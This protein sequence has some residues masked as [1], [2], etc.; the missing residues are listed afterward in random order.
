MRLTSLAVAASVLLAGCSRPAGHNEGGDQSPPAFVD[1]GETC[2]IDFEHVH[3]GSGRHYFLE[4]ANAGVALFDYDEDGDLD[5]Y[6][7][8]CQL[9]DGPPDPS[10]VNRLYRNEGDNRFTP[11]DGTGL[12]DAGYG[13]GVAVGDYDGDG[14]EDVYVTNYGPNR[15]FRNLGGGRFADVTAEAGVGDQG[16]GSS[17]AFLDYDS[18]GDLDLY[19]GNYL[20]YTP[21]GDPLCDRAGTPTYCPP[22]FY[23]PQD[24]VF[25]RNNG[26]GTFSDVSEASGILSVAPGRTLGCLAAD[27]DGDGDTD[28]Y[29]TND[30]TVNRLFENLGGEFRDVGA[31]AGISYGSLGREAG[32]MGVDAGDVDGDGDLDLTVGNFSDES[33]EVQISQGG[34]RFR[35]TASTGAIARDTMPMVTFA[36]L[37]LDFDL[38]SDL[39][40]FYANGH[41]YD[42]VEQRPQRGSWAQPDQLF[43]NDGTGLFTSVPPAVAGPYFA[44]RLLG[45]GGA[46]GDLDGDGDEDIVVN[47]LLGRP[48]VLINQAR[49]NFLKVRLRPTASNPSAI[50]ARLWA[51]VSGRELLRHVADG[52]SFCSVCSRDIVFG[53]GEA[54]Q[55][56]ELLVVWPSGRES[57]LQDLPA[58]RT[59]E[60]VEP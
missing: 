33:G 52:R 53:L 5:V 59:V 12:E 39:D 43:A 2:G 20:D 27:L 48:T 41:V 21:E 46:C 36:A 38:D 34:L 11:V 51:T 8:Q 6:F 1:I 15:L 55:V 50:G 10:L 25:Y 4:T 30:V 28:L 23:D 3:G 47:N 45:R 42:N 37:F 19:V 58:G 9:I 24:N 57:R 7:T 14:H 26:D 44:T 40:I 49:G 54:E 60:V 35:D 16:L 17:A 13:M 29:V 18:D 31:E 56:D 32:S 22:F